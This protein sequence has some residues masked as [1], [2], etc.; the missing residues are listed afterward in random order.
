MAQRACSGKCNLREG[1]GGWQHSERLNLLLIR[2]G[3]IWSV[4]DQHNWN[5]GPLLCSWSCSFEKSDDIE[6]AGRWNQC[7]DNNER[8]ITAITFSCR[9]EKII[10]ARNEYEAK[11]KT[12]PAIP[13]VAV[14]DGT[15]DQM[16]CRGECCVVTFQGPERCPVWQHSQWRLW[17][18]KGN[19][20][21][22]Y[23]GNEEERDIVF[24]CAQGFVR[25]KHDPSAHQLPQEFSNQWE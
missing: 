4:G 19:D 16:G 21:H 18:Y 1:Q 6:A 23:V 22:W 25:S 13:K 5:A 24:D 17:L 9:E 2:T 11:S 14:T 7:D 8:M 20:G 10:K 15:E 12:C 3:K